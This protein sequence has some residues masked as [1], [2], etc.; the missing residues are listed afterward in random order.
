MSEHRASI[1]DTWQMLFHHV[2]N[3]NKD[4]FNVSTPMLSILKEHP[5]YHFRLFYVETFV[6]IESK[7]EKELKLK[8]SYQNVFNKSIH[9][10]S[11][12]KR[13]RHHSFFVKNSFF[14]SVEGKK[15]K[16]TSYSA[17]CHKYFTFSSATI[18]ALK[19]SKTFYS[20][21]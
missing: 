2:A 15:T 11:E 6:W 14:N 3:W 12:S 1:P 20:F 7:E 8:K 9:C 19:I 21:E 10:V 13:I 5:F 4:V 16:K 17:T 18:I